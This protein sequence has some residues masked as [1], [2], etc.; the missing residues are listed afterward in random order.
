MRANSPSW[1]GTH[2]IRA[3]LSGFRTICLNSKESL[4]KGADTKLGYLYRDKGFLSKMASNRYIDLLYHIQSYWI[5]CFCLPPLPSELTVETPTRRDSI[6]K[7]D[8]LF[9]FS[10][11]FNQ[12]IRPSSSIAAQL[13]SRAHAE[14]ASDTLTRYYGG[15]RNDGVDLH[16]LYSG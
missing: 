10:I 8:I 6:L 5:V 3:C 14:E 7:E 1:T 11:Q 16:P 15:R 12:G 13:T 2:L 4:Y 9:L